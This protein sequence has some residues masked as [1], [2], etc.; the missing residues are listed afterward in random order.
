[1]GSQKIAVGL[2]SLWNGIQAAPNAHSRAECL[3]CFNA[4]VS[5]REDFERWTKLR[6]VGSQSSFWLC[7]TTIDRALWA[8]I[9]GVQLRSYLNL[10]A[11]AG[12]QQDFE[13]THTSVIINIFRK[14]PS[15]QATQGGI[16]EE[17]SR[18]LKTHYKAIARHL[19][20]HV[21][22]GQ[23]RHIKTLCLADRRDRNYM[24]YRVAYETEAA[25]P[26]SF[27]YL[28][29]ILAWEILES[30]WRAIGKR[31]GSN[32]RWAHQV[33][34]QY[35]QYFRVDWGQNL[36]AETLQRIDERVF[37]LVCLETFKIFRRE[38]LEDRNGVGGVEWRDLRFHP[39]RTPFFSLQVFDSE[40]VCLHW[41]KESR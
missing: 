18:R 41:F 17:T 37:S 9:H 13:I 27:A 22:K 10:A 12:D 4:L 20:R 34:S 29:W 19:R 26:E 25:R 28:S 31:R 1:M 14:H 7:E 6:L 33:F 16:L 35:L 24:E 8:Q 40:N 3:P 15:E 38:Y 5:L 30:P 21:L 32:H 2:E 39:A 36:S 11:G 23:K